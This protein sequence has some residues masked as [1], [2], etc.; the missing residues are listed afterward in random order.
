M[1]RAIE[2]LSAL[3]VSRRSAKAGLHHDG[4][5]LGLR[6]SPSRACSW[7]YRY[8]LRGNAR[9]MG[10]GSYPEI[11]LS[12]AR[13]L[14]TEARRQKALGND[15]IAVRDAIRTHERIEA[16]RSVTFR[17]CAKSYIG[18][19][20]AGW[21]NAKHGAQWSATLETYAMPVIGDMPVQAVDVSLV[22]KILEPIWNE[23]TETAS[24]V[25]GR[26]EAILDWATVRGF[27]KGDN[28]ARWKGHLENLFPKRSKVQAVEHHS[29]LPYSEIGAF[30]GRL[31]TQDGASSTALKLTILTAARTGEIVGARWKEIDF[32]KAIWTVP[33]SRMKTGREHR[34]PLSKAALSLLGG[35]RELAGQSEFVFPGSTRAKSISNM[36]MLQLLRRIGRDDLTVH[37]FRSTFRDWA[38]E[39]TAYSNEVAEAALA[40]IVGDK[41]EAAYRRGDLFEKRRRLMAD[42]AAYCHAPAR[43]TKVIPIRHTN[44][45]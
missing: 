1:G 12:D 44:R 38:A 18:S 15:P 30:M 5:G 21:K 26:V 8:M 35:Q 29:A 39:C 42:W 24:R 19:R 10:L 3:A 16:A 33:G 37:G 11:S 45:A 31:K 13:A 27:R 7:V 36:A 4:G 34:V 40:H 22:H 41:V 23:K 14:A 25:R 32:N 2:K 20:K 6:V 17:D 43:A 9:E 28:P